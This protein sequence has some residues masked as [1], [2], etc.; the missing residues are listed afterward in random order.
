M[1]NARIFRLLALVSLNLVGVTTA[2]NWHAAY[3][4]DTE[5]SRTHGQLFTFGVAPGIIGVFL[6]FAM[7]HVILPTHDQPEFL[8]RLAGG[9]AGI[10]AIFAGVVVLVTFAVGIC[11]LITLGPGVDFGTFGMT[12]LNGVMPYVVTCLVL[13]A[14]SFQDSW[15]QSDAEEIEIVQA[16]PSVASATSAV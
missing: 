4:V 3:W 16:Q 14:L 11:S 8:T 9:L 15:I 6:A 1:P 7:F 2:I 13:I 12:T 10:G 5:S